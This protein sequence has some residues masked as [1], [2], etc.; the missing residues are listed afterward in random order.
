MANVPSVP[1]TAYLFCPAY[2]L[3]DAA[4]EARA[5]A[6]AQ[7]LCDATGLELVVSPLLGRR[8]AAGAWL[9]TSERRCDL[10][11]AVSNHDV[12]L[13]ARGGYG[14]LDLVPSLHLERQ[15]APVLVGYS[16]LTVLHAC[17]QRN[18]WGESLYGFLP[19][20]GAGP[21]SLDSTARLLRGEGM[22]WTDRECPAVRRLAPG[23]TRA[24]VAAAC[25]RVL[26]GLAGTPA[27][28]DLGG[29][30]LAIEDIDER[31]YRV[32]R[33]LWQLHAAGCLSGLAGLVGGLFTAEAPSGYGGPDA[34]QVLASWAQRL[35]VPA[36]TGLPFG[37]AD[38]PLTLPWGRAV[39]L[40]V[41]GDA[42]S[43]DIAP[44]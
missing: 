32:D 24:P 42:W 34:G 29:R 40:D 20:V 27:M 15:G 35:E 41:S 36:I 17:W 19:G 21:R 23:R 31:P 8:L 28:P 38:D 14:C 16:D 7:A 25:L 11:Q 12:L 30:I 5:V 37:H 43:L 39:G 1:R 18:G 6:G 4:Q 3:A 10:V 9:P 13:A 22:R 33:D 44:R 2:P 26:A